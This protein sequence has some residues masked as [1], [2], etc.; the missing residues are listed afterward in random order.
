M[1]FRGGGSRL[2]EHYGEATMDDSSFM[3][4][5]GTTEQLPVRLAYRKQNYRS[6]VVKSTTLA[7]Y[8]IPMF[9]AGLGFANVYQD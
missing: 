5:T 6:D 7:L 3:E 2:V 1:G 4:V 8:A 9:R